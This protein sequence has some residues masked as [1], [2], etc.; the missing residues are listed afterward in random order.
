MANRHSNEDI[1]CR[2]FAHINF[3]FGPRFEGS[4]L[5]LGRVQGSGLSDF[6]QAQIVPY[7]AFTAYAKRAVEPP[8]ASS[9]TRPARSKELPSPE[10]LT[11]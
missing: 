1:K 10:M 3:S 9:S 6:N 4:D 11:I 7:S 2:Y 8:T 5:G